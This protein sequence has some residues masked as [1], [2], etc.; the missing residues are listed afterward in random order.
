MWKC[1][2]REAACKLKRI[3]PSRILRLYIWKLNRARTPA[4]V[5]VHSFDI[6]WKKSSPTIDKDRGRG[7]FAA[8]D[9]VFGHAR[10]VAGVSQPGF[11]DDEI[12]VGC[13]DKIGVT[14]W[15]DH[16]LVSLPLHLKTDFSGQNSLQLDRQQLATT[17]Y[18]STVARH[19]VDERLL[20]RRVCVGGKQRGTSFLMQSHRQ[21]KTRR[22]LVWYWDTIYLTPCW[23]EYLFAS[24]GGRL[25]LLF[26]S[27]WTSL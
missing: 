27:C 23:F 2:T 6:C 1:G 21:R 25:Q 17:P 14:R 3:H 7:A 15:V 19:D 13:D 20:R 22:G 11:F 5:S 10:V 24:C 9:D 12:M 8:S 18:S 26:C 16:I 4:L